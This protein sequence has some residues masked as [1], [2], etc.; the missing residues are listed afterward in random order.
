MQR[1]GLRYWVEKRLDKTLRIKWISPTAEPVVREAIRQIK[2]LTAK[3]RE[4]A[5]VLEANPTSVPLPPHLASH[6]GLTE[7]EVV[8]LLGVKIHGGLRRQAPNSLRTTA[9]RGRAKAVYDRRDVEALLLN[10]RVKHLHTMRF[11]D[12]SSQLLSESLFIVFHNESRFQTTGHCKLLVEPVTYNHVE[13][14][15][16]C[17]WGTGHTSLFL[18]GGVTEE[19]RRMTI[20]PHG[21]RHWLHHIAYKGG[22]PLHLITRYF[23]RKDDCDTLDY[24]HSIAA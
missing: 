5:K 4:R 11:N 20:R 9:G 10:R 1:Y 21:F 16:R 18:L 8:Q 24:L 2:R 19:E 7:A 15:L 3:A 12:G 17:A 13:K 6:S 14:F 23:G 22:M